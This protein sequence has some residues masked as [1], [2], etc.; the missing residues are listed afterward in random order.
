MVVER[1]GGDVLVDMGAGMVGGAWGSGRDIWSRERLV[2]RLGWRLA[3]GR[4]G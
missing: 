3:G 1:G 2:R 4:C